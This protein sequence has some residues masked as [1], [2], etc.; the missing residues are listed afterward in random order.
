MITICRIVAVLMALTAFPRICAQCVY[1]P[2]DS[3]AIEQLLR[4]PSEEER[5]TLFF[6]RQFL[7]RPYVAHTL[8]GNLQEHLVVNTR[9]L[10]CT[11]LVETVLSLTLCAYRNDTTFEAYCRQLQQMR[12]RHGRI[13]GYPSRLHYFSD[14]IRDNTRKGL[15]EEVQTPVSPFTAVQLLNINYM[16]Q[17]SQ[18]YEA[19][20]RNPAFLPIIAEQE[21]RLSGLR[22]R[23]IPKHKVTNSQE[24]RDAVADGDIIAITTSKAGLDVAHLGFALWRG[25]G[26]HLLNAS[27]IHHKVVVEPMTLRQYLDQHPSFTGL[28]IIKLLK[29]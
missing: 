18:S 13:D 19:L 2:E 15:I 8:E 16:S 9:Q 6:A 27:S 26:L 7:G 11:T 1:T 28:R 10:D 25:D 4:L 20:S 17:H 23:Y 14:W 21:R 3:I 5:G 22:F 12:Y 24:L 29:P